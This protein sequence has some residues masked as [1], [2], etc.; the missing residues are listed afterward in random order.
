MRVENLS[1][2]AN[3][4]MLVE[5]YFEKW[6]GPVENTIILPLEQAAII[7]FKNEEGK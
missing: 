4:K 5:L 1:A 7:T 2:E 3:N 6:G